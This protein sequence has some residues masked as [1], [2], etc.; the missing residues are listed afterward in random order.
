MVSQLQLTEHLYNQDFDRS[1]NS[2]EVLIG[3]LRKRLGDKVIRTKRG[4]GYYI[5]DE[6]E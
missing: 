3:R 2:I 5:A 1:S 6:K 4:F